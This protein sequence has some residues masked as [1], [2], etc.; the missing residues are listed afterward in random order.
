VDN[1]KT[2]ILI[3][4][5]GTGKSSL[6]NSLLGKEEFVVGHGIDAGT[7]LACYRDG[8]MLGR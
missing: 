7:I 8:Y 4:E 5:T 6:G 1:R 3:E 2:I